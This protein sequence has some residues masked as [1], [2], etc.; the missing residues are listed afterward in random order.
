MSDEKKSLAQHIDEQTDRLADA[1][2]RRE[3]KAGVDKII[4]VHPTTLIVDQVELHDR[5]PECPQPCGH[6][7]HE[8]GPDGE[9]VPPKSTAWTDDARDAGAKIAEDATAAVEH[10]H[11][12]GGSELTGLELAP[13]REL[14]REERDALPS[15]VQVL[16]PGLSVTIGGWRTRIVLIDPW[17]NMLMLHVGEPTN[18][19]VKRERKEHAKA[20]VLSH[21]KRR[22]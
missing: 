7:E 3:D 10:D 22:K 5:G 12:G 19:A 1:I 13:D 16:R 6:S 4:G 15:W 21:K 17:R 18:S 2:T 8:I 9:L 14:T 11:A 20:L